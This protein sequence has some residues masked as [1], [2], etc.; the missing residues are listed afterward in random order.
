MK[1]LMLSA[2]A[3]GLMA[4]PVMAQPAS[5][6]TATLKVF[7]WVSQQIIDSTDN[8]IERFAKK[9]PN[10]TIE[11]QFAPLSTWG[12]YNNS[13]INQAAAGDTP[14]IFG[15]AIE[16]FSQSAATG[17]LLDLGPI[18]D[19]DASAQAVLADIE[20]NLLEGM[21]TR[22]S[23]ELNFFP[24]E[25]NNIVV[26]YNKDMFDAAG[27]AYPADDW[28][29]QD[30]RETAEAL[31]VRDDNG[32]VSQYGYFVPGYN[33][34][35]T[36]WFYTND[37]GI[38]D[39]EWREPAVTTENF[40]ET[41]QFLHDLINVD[42]SAPAFE[43]GVGDDKFVAGQV[44]MFSAGHWPIPEIVESGLENVGVQIMPINK[45]N[46]TVFGI[47]GLSITKAAENPDLAWEFIKEL[48]GTEFQQE[49][50]DS[51]RSIPSSRSA[52]ANADWLAFPT[53]SEIFY[54]SAATAL[55]VAAPANFAQVE[56]IFMRHMGAYMNDN[57]DLDTTIDQLDSELSRAMRRVNK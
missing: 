3:V 36:P 10:V 42:H 48:T 38:L 9:Y 17:L 52:A 57:Q 41:L 37:A 2:V 11:P 44:A 46:A 19:A 21:R 28:T 29:W 55:P 32:N 39:A 1:K 8:A 15:V 5:D 16:G 35:A 43:T 33:F 54:G 31:T 12:E 13:F 14:D 40:R 47:G 27:I 7:S 18:I 4:Q 24:T 25:W 34:G 23:D 56:E 26:Y 6:I 51:Q 30:F 22:P 49:L 20:G 53:N 45:V 50:A